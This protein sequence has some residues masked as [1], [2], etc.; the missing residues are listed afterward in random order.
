MGPIDNHVCILL[1]LKE[2]DDQ[3][4]SIQKTRLNY[5]HE[6]CLTL[7]GSWKEPYWSL[8]FVNHQKR[9]V[10]C[11]IAKA[12]CTTWLRFLLQLTDSRSAINLAKKNRYDVHRKV[13]KFISR[14]RNIK[15]S[16]R[17]RYLTGNYYKVMIV[18]DPLDRLISGYR[19]KMFQHP[20]YAKN[21]MMIDRF[22]GLDAST[23]FSIKI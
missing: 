6:K 9:V 21:F 1:Q 13:D 14:M 16:E 18:R 7:R 17:L 8:I 5:T 22:L 23:R 4:Q 20:G 3:R 10:M 2:G 19:D 15:A 12:A 11:L